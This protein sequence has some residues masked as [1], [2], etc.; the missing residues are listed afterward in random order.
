M[1]INANGWLYVISG[2]EPE[3]YQTICY[4]PVSRGRIVLLYQNGTG[5]WVGLE[6]G[7]SLKVLPESTTDVEVAIAAFEKETGC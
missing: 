7:D 5:Y 4:R 1:I 3:P 2:L 6:D